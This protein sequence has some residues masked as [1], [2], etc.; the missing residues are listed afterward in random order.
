M[1]DYTGQLQAVMDTRTVLK[2]CANLSFLFTELP[3]L[4]RFQA[5]ATAGFT[6]VEYLSPYEYPPEQIA[7]C[8][9]AA[10]LEQVLFNLPAGDW[11]AGERGLAVL[12]EREAE[13]RASVE[14]AAQYAEAL[15]CRQVHC[16]AGIIPAGGDEAE[17]R[18][19]YV[20]NLRFAA[21][22]LAHSGVTVTIEPINSMLDMPGY[23]LDSVEKALS[24][25]TE[26]AC[27]N[28]KLQ[29][30][31]YHAHIMGAETA[32]IVDSHFADLAHVQV[33]DA[34]GRHE[35]GTGEIDFAVLFEQLQRVGYR[36]WIGCEYRPQHNTCDGLSWRKAY[37]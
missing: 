6:G 22:Y 2:F 30:D 1:A 3:F 14:L 29:L 23:W 7:Q 15:G 36:G 21:D 20:A 24:L 10:G 12:P 11:A 18:A 34:P 25:L 4:E 31:F 32:A 33:A 8:L 28:V 9:K 19:R 17:C 13:F 37:T 26:I 5:A 16:M 27:P 35:P